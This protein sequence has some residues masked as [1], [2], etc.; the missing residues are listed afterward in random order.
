MCLM[1]QID[2][3]FGGVPLRA[4]LDAMLA[5]PRG[6]D[7]PRHLIRDL[8]KARTPT[9]SKDWGRGLG[10]CAASSDVAVRR[11]CGARGKGVGSARGPNNNLVRGGP[12]RN[13]RWLGVAS[14]R[15]WSVKAR[16]SQR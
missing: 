16:N 2:I 1:Q 9:P 7:V 11:G 8:S 3:A 6:T 5:A 12:F 14:V 15:L 10:R 13:W 4:E